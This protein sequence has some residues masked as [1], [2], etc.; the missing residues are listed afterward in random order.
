MIKNIIFDM[1]GTLSNT[2]IATLASVKEI[3]QKYQLPDLTLEEIHHAMGIGGFPFYQMLFPTVETSV[4]KEVEKE[5]DIL[6]DKKIE[7]FGRSILFHGVYEMLTSLKDNGYNLHIASTG[8]PNHVKTTLS[9]S[10]ILCFFSTVSCNEPAKIHMVKRIIDNGNL[11]EWAMVGDMFKDSEAARENNILA[12]GAAFGYLSPEDFPLFDKV[13]HQPMDIF[14]LLAD[15]HHI[16][17]HT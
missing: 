1:D 3:E 17:A 5:V 8:N 14:S 15:K 9:A 12:V 4:L 6:E 7:E 2:A 16:Q 11:N 13:I 10:G